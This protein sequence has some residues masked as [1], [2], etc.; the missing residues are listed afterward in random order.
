MV[1]SDRARGHPCRHLSH[2]SVPG[3][4]RYE[5]S[6]TKRRKST[7]IDVTLCTTGSFERCLA[8]QEFPGCCYAAFFLASNKPS[9]LFFLRVPRRLC[10]EYSDKGACDRQARTL[11]GESGLRANRRKPFRFFRGE[12]YM[13]ISKRNGR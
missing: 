7:T 2:E 5:F 11:R 12:D 10:C 1:R 3:S 6:R 9:G 8:C 4:P 13:T